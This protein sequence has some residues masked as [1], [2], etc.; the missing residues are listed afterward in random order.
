MPVVPL[1][2]SPRDEQPSRGSRVVAFL[3]R[4]SISTGLA[5]VL[6]AVLLIMLPRYDE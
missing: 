4:L 6:G 2:Y 3:R 5:F 1:D